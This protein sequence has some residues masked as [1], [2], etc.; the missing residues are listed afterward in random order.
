MNGGEQLSGVPIERRIA[1]AA[2]R[3]LLSVEHT[4][5]LL[6]RHG[7]ARTLAE[8]LVHESVAA[9][10]SLTAEEEHPLIRAALEP[11]GVEGEEALVAWLEKRHWDF[12]DLRACAT[13]QDRLRRWREW[14]FGSEVEIRFLERKPDLDRVAYSLL[15]VSDGDLA[16]EL[17][18]RLRDDGAD[19]ASLVEIFSEGSETATRG[20]I[21]PVAVSAGHPELSRRLRVGVPGQLWPPFEVAGSWLLIR[22]ERRLPVQL[23][24]PMVSRMV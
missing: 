20:L 6:Q 2:G 19:F 11:E 10:V 14:R 21:G 8:A 13:L 9:T 12:E 22:L 24:P 3:P 5:R 1:L 7:L 23:D 4:N 17:Y 18:F 15:R 16:Q